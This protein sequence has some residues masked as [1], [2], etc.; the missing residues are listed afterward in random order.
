MS[1]NNILK[2][3]RFSTEPNSISATSE[4]KHWFSTLQ[5]YIISIEPPPSES[6]KLRI[7]TNCI[8]HNVYEY[9]SLSG[10]F[11]DAISILKTIYVK[12]V[13]EVF[14]RHKLAT[15]RQQPGESIDQYLLALASLGKECQFKAVTA[16]KNRDDSVR[17][18][19]ISGLQ[20]LAIRQRLLEK[21]S[22]TL[23]EAA[24]QARSLE[25]AQAQSLSFG[26]PLHINA[27]PTEPSEGSSAESQTLASTQQKCYFCGRDKH[28]RNSCPANNSICSHCSKKGH[29][30]KVC[31]SPASSGKGPKSQSAAILNANITASTGALTNTTVPATINGSLVSVLIDTG[32]SQSYISKTTALRLGLT[33]LPYTGVVSMAST[34][35]TS[36]ITG[37]CNVNLSVLN[38]SYTNVNL[39]ILPD[40]CADVIVGHDLLKQH[41]SIQVI[42]GGEKAPLNICSLAIAHVQ[43]ASLFTHLDSNCAPI[44]T[45]SRRHSPY[46]L[47]FIK[48]EINRMLKEDIIESSMSPWRAQVLVVSGE[49]R[50]R[51][52]CIDYS[53]TINRFTLLDAYPLPL[54]DDII[55]KVAC[56]E[57]FSTIDL[58]S[59]YHQIPIR[60]EDKYYTAFEADGNLYQFK[61]IPFGVTNGVA[62]FQRVIDEVIRVE[63]LKDTYAYLDDVTVCG[64]TQEEHDANLRNFMDAAKKY[65]LTL[66]TEK[67]SFSLKSINL[68]G[69][70]I[71]NG[72]IK[73][74]HNR[75]KPLRELQPPK[76]TASLRR[77]LGMFSHYSSQIP[78]FSEKVLPLT[79][80][81]FPLS[82]DALQAFENL[83]SD[84]EKSSVAGVDPDVPFVVETDASDGAI[85]AVLTQLG[86]P[87]AFFSRSLSGSELK[88]SSVEKEAQAIVEALEKWRH[89]LIG[90]HFTL[91]TDQR[92][93]A[94]MF[95]YR[96]HG[97]VKNDKIMRWRMD[98]SCFRYDIVYRP[99]KENSA[100]DALSRICSAISHSTEKLREFHTTLCHPGVTRLYHW[101]RSKNLPYS[102]DEIRQITASCDI[103]AAVKPRFHKHQGTLIK[104]T[105]PFERLNIDFKGPL[106]TVSTNRYLLVI[107]DEYSRFPFAFPCRD[108]T[109]STVIA[110]LTELFSMFGTP[111]YIH[112]DRGASFMAQ[113]L[114]EFLNKLGVAT[115]R[116][117]PYNPAG[118][119]QVERFN[120]IIWKSVELALKTR[121]LE[122]SKWES[123]LPD[124]LHSV[125]SLLCTATNATPHERMFVHPRRTGNGSSA[126]S[127]LLEPGPIFLKQHVRGSKY[128]PVVEPVTL[129]HGNAEYSHVRMPDGR[130]TTVSSRHLAPMGQSH[131]TTVESLDASS[132]S[133]A[134]SHQ[135]AVETV[136][137]TSASDASSTPEDSLPTPPPLTECLHAPGSPV[138]L[139]KSPPLSTP[140]RVPSSS[141]EREP[142]NLRRSTRPK[143]APA[144]LQDYVPN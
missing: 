35:I 42:F 118:N 87:V 17:D 76:D 101:V 96:H 136:D 92:S 133:D 132:T 18:A 31:R 24:G 7:L 64:K 3:Y 142:S 65:N 135:T 74:D 91:I 47:A 59:A 84:I 29:Y 1:E 57:V 68:L 51:R 15:R 97:K 58:R 41:S 49:N 6:Q 66:N 48:E 43:P 122:I 36:T 22:L 126:P 20:S 93:V 105:S 32:S 71:S 63:N 78:K 10:T 82:K 16:E 23:E 116:T 27:L 40:L 19:F 39:A 4:W 13:N 112:S 45:K 106:P 127:W 37:R 128:D 131:Q 134:H 94:F 102:L 28:P 21:I 114:K 88:H 53:R 25:L 130:E 139:T 117:T 108:M 60:E 137:K 143:R 141:P 129:L 86:R 34:S 107:V 81:T 104:A 109:S 61:R 26:P 54:I 124:A 33:I 69:Y 121:K 52:M 30:S 38:H 9:V 62:A 144:Y 100:A 89:Y 98:L 95:D 75:L 5:N 56:H 103:C 119:G 14:A 110:K 77:A 83:K 79:R 11:N 90:R 111:A 50:K 138:L 8:S 70:S 44:A 72:V 46:D 85:A 120:G 12:P 55:N 2:P 123:V 99:G 113:D 140:S 67:S 73:P 125:R 80:S 115:S